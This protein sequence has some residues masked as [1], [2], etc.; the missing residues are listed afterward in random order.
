MSFS[1]DLETLRASY[2]G[3]T[4]TPTALVD[5]I[6]RRIDAHGDPAVWIHRLSRD[7]LLVHARRVEARGPAEQPLFGV[8]FAIKDNI[9][10]AGVPTTAACP[11]F[12]YTP[13]A[14]ATVVQRLL[15]AGAI[16]VG[17]T[18]LDQFATGL[19]G[20][21]SPH[22]VPRNPFH[23]E[24]IPGGSSSGSAVAVAAGLV[25]FALGTD[26]AGSGR[27]PAMFNNLV[28]VKPTRGWFS[29]RG[30]V[31]AC[32]SLDCVSVF[33]LTV[34]EATTVAR[35]CGGFDPADSFSRPAP[36]EAAAPET[37]ASLTPFWFGVP[38]AD[39]LEWFGDT[40]SPVAFAAAV[41][42]FERLGGVRVEIDFASFRDAARLLYEGPWVAERWAAVRAFHAKNADAIFPVTRKIIEGG[43]KPLAVDAFE[44]FYQ[45]A[46]LRR[47]AD[48][49]WESIDAL[50][51]PTAAT[52]YTRAQVE[53]D[54]ITLNSRLGHYTNFANLLDTAALAVP[55]GFRVDGLPFGVTL[56]GPAWSDEKLAGLG[57]AFHRATGHTL[58]ATGQP[59]PEKSV[60]DEIH[61]AAPTRLNLAVVGAHLTGQPLNREL[62][63]RGGRLVR[64]TQTANCYRLHA[65]VGTVPPKPGLERVTPG[66]GV[67][68]EVE[69]WSLAPAAWAEFVAAIPP[70]LGIGTLLLED[71]TAVKGFLC[72]P[73][74]LVGSKDISHFGGWRAY[75]RDSSSNP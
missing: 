68:I 54:P 31:P 42:G 6:C 23:P 73:L 49:V 5:E 63:S 12:S 20:V 55:A 69:V 46:A 45:L 10:L 39:Q 57:S 67:A 35:I 22:G 38:A 56:F 50:L 53:A 3:G 16:P 18:N 48:K 13:P 11:E 8:P 19:V 29:T 52:I 61:P 25:S 74:A 75:R 72:E 66:E 64:T 34:G 26:T 24:M 43:A 30:V 14:S 17:K 51:L 27:V 37:A 60:A 36:A 28:G 33:A 40:L 4:L 59:L 15:E 2:A 62:T 21:R 7:E 41:R 1:L 70:P 47:A 9:D 32:R 65:L 71:G 58:G 44:A